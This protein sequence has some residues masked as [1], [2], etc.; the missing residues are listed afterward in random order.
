M[1]PADELKAYDEA[2]PGAA[3]EIIA[4]ARDEQRNRHYCMRAEVDA[5][6]RGQVFAIAAYI[7]TI[8]ACVWIAYL[9]ASAVAG[10]IGTAAISVFGGAFLLN[11]HLDKKRESPPQQSSSEEKSVQIKQQKQRRRSS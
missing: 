7:S 9:G 3:A 5:I 6:K 8:S 10:T 11:R 1:P 2:S 4:M